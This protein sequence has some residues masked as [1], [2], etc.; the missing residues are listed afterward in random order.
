MANDREFRALLAAVA[1]GRLAP[2]IDRVL[3]LAQAPDAY[4][5]V[6]EGRQFGKIVLVPDGLGRNWPD[7]D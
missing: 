4:R 6:E 7:G 5:L 2:R 1:A 3:P